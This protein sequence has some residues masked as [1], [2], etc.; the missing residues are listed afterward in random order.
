[1]A[2]TKRHQPAPSG[3]VMDEFLKYFEIL[4]IYVTMKNDD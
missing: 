4:F 3:Y 1:M 2:H